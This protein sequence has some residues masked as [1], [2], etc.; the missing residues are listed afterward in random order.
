M[1]QSTFGASDQ[2]WLLSLV[3]A[4]GAAISLEMDVTWAVLLATM[5]HGKPRFKVPAKDNGIES[6]C[7]V[8]ESW[9]ATYSDPIRV[10][11]GGPI[12]LNGRQDKWDGWVWP[13]AENRG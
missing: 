2:P 3:A 8:T 9:T 5:K 13:W 7:R 12:E 11:A 6:F 1:V 4:G 10:L